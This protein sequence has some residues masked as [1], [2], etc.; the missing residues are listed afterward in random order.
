MRE[1]NR[2]CIL[3]VDE[4]YVKASIAYRGGQL[5]EYVGDCPGKI[6]TTLLAE[7]VTDNM[8]ICALHWPQDT[9]LNSYGVPTLPPSLFPNVP[10]SFIP[11]TSAAT[12][13]TTKKASFEAR[14]V[15]ADE[16]EA[17][18][19]L[20][21]LD[22]STFL[23]T[24]R[25][26]M[27][28]IDVLVVPND[29]NVMLPGLT[30]LRKV[31]RAAR[32]LEDEKLFRSVFSQMR[33]GNRGC[34]LIVDEIYVKASIAYRGGQL[35]GYAADY[36]GKIATTLLCVMAKCF[37]GSKSFLVKLIPCHA[38]KADFQF[39]IV[40][41]VI[42]ML[43]SC[44]A[45]VFGIITD[46]NRVNQAFFKSFTVPDVSKPWIAQSPIASER[47]LF[48]IYDPVHLFKNL[49]NSWITEKTKSLDFPIGPTVK[50]ARWSDLIEI[51]NQEKDSLLKL[52]SLTH[53][54]L[55]PN[56][57]EKQKVSLAIEV[58]SE[59]TSAAL[60]TCSISTDSCKETSV[61]LDEVVRLWKVFNSKSPF[62]KSRHRDPDRAIID[63]TSSG[64][65]QLDTLRKWAERAKQ[66]EPT[67]RPRVR[68]LTQDTAQA[69]HWTCQC[70]CDVSN[71]LLTTDSPFRHSYVAP[72]F[73]QQ[74]DIEQHFGHFRMS[75]GCNFYIT[76]A[77]VAH[78]HAIDRAKLMLYHE[79][80]TPDLT[81]SSHSCHM[82]KKALTDGEILLIDDLSEEVAKLS[83]DE[84][85]SIHHIGGYLVFKENLP[86]DTSPSHPQ[87]VSSYTECL[88]RG[89]LKHP[90][91][92]LYKESLLH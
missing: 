22:S 55:F 13:R 28:D 82:C 9:P 78:T 1:G 8:G 53:A 14:N 60:K 57:I 54:S 62:Q 80:E 63:L 46:N 30:T 42:A 5:F 69:L 32:N 83:S 19:K 84:K 16:M 49:R 75:A 88:D 38:L 33:E 39:Q 59:K 61:F 76:A 24:L 81:A 6:A 4:I 79:L 72:G 11:S 2:G 40:Q 66:M 74:D 47:P 15:S 7:N 77:E 36:P 67:S 68:A 27:K 64:E 37:F 56:N 89:G 86:A 31:T 71:Y 20:D 17:F 3:I 92:E 85:M 23:D 51:Y 50:T 35:F 18:N 45:N 21:K 58:F 44:G 52:S 34:I 29:H 10:A 41:D 91:D 65:H 90:P 87:S 73:F 12:P 70:L 43:E 26:R 48:L 25:E